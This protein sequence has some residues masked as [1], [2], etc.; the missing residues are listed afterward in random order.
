MDK[1]TLR[2][3]QKKLRKTVLAQA[4]TVLFSTLYD[5]I[6]SVLRT[7]PPTYTVA[8][9][10]P[11]QDE[12][13]IRP[14]LQNITNPT[15]LPC[16][17]AQGEPLIFRTWTQ[18]DDMEHDIYHIPCPRDTTPQ[19][20]PECLLVPLLAFDSRGYRLG[21]GGGFYDRTIAHDRPKITLGI[22]LECLY[23]DTV[24]TDTYDQAC[25][26]IITET[27]IIEIR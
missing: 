14:V 26:H 1:N 25:T 21:Y 15:A 22:G 10:F 13:D 12:I 5:N 19:V 24:P 7:I 4:D 8:G 6:I 18:E 2:I 23:V 17:I 9:Y 16:T 11:M 27:R 20:V 3:H